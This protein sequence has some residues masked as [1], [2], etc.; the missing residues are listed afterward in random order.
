ME[1]FEDFWAVYPRR[2]DRARAEKSWR[3]ELRKKGVTA[4]R[5]IEAAAAYAEQTRD[6]EAQFVKHPATW[7]NA[8]AYDNDPEP[9]RRLRAVSGGHRPFQGY[10]ESEYADP[11]DWGSR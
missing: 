9:E 1:R 7:L 2:K 11:P 4:E 5:L 3:A 10:D 8:G 6:S